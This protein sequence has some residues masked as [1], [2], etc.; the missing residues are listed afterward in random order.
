MV[1][2]EVMIENSWSHHL[3]LDGCDGSVV[4]IH[5]LFIELIEKG[6]DGM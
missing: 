4:V 3:R 1:V 5:Q 6:T 2:D